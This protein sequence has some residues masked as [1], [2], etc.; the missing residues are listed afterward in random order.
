MKK[1]ETNQTRESFIE[2]MR[3]FLDCH[4]TNETKVDDLLDFAIQK[5][6]LGFNH[7]GV[8]WMANQDSVKIKHEWAAHSFFDDGGGE[9]G[10]EE[11]SINFVET[12]EDCRIQNEKLNDRER[13]SLEGHEAFYVRNPFGLAGVFEISYFREVVDT[14]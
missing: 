1:K 4:G 8:E 13:Y 7:Y 12:E 2:E 9:I 14:D 6:G 5:T 10:R 3:H 11:W